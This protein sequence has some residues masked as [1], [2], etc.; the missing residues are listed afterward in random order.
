V[1][2]KRVVALKMILAGGHAGPQEVARF[3]VEAEAAARLQ[4]PHIVQIFETGQHAGLPYFSLEFCPGGSLHAKLAGTP[5]PPRAAARLVEQLAQG[6]AYAHQKGIVH[7]D[8][9]PGNVLLAEDGTPKI[10]DFGLAKHLQGEPGAA[11]GEPGALATG[12]LTASGAVMGTPSYMAPEQAGGKSGQVG[13]AADVYALGA[14]LYECLTGRPPFRAATLPETLLQ[15][16][17]EEPVAVRQLQPG[18]P[19]DLETI[20]HK[21]LQKEPGKRYAGAEELAEDLRRF[22][23]GEPI[24]AR[25][26]GPMERAWRWCRRNPLVAGLTAAVAAALLVGATV[27]TGFALAASAEARRARESERRA[28]DDRKQADLARRQAEKDKKRANAEARKAVQEKDE[29]DR[30]LTRADTLLYASQ[31]QRADE[32]WQEGKCF[33][34]R[35]LLNV[36]KRDYRRF[37][38]RY[39]HALF[40]GSHLSFRGHIEFVSSVAFSPDGKRLASGSSDKTVKVWNVQTGQDILTFKGHTSPVLS[41]AFSPNG[42]RLVSCSGD[43]RHSP[44]EVKVWDAQTGRELLDLKG[45]KDY[46]LSVA[47]SPDGKC[48]AS[49]SRDMTVKVWDAQ[50]GRQLLDLKGHTT[51]VDSVAFSP[52]GRRL[53]SG[54]GAF[55]KPGE[56]KIWDL[57]TGLEAIPLKGHADIVTSVVFSPD[58]KHLATAS[59]DRAV[60]VWDAQTGQEIL[61][62]KGH[63]DIVRSVAFSPDGQSLATASFDKTVKVWD[64]HAGQELFLLKGH[65][66]AV[67]SVAFSPDGQ[68]LASGSWDKIV[69]VWDARTGQQVLPIKEQTQ[70]GMRIAFSPDGQRLASGSGGTGSPIKVRICDV[71]TGQAIFASRRPLGMLVPSVAFSPDGQR[72]A[73]ACQDGTV[74][75]WNPQ[76]GQRVLTLRGHTRAVSSVAFSSDSKRLAS[77]SWD[78]TVKVWDALKGRQLLDLKG[79]NYVLSVAFSPD[80]RRLATA[81]LTTTGKP[82]DVKVWDARTG[83]ELLALKGQTDRVNSLAFSPDGRHLASAALDKTVKVWDARTGQETFTLKGHTDI[84]MCV[85]FSPDGKHLASASGDKTVKLWDARTGLEVLSLRGHT[86]T[87]VSV[88]FSPDGECLASA[89]GDQTVKVWDAPRREKF[90]ARLEDQV[91]THLWH[92]RMAQQ[93]RQAD[94]AF[95]L[96]FHLKP[97]LLT[98]FTRWQDRPHNFFPFWAWRPPVI[99]TLAPVSS[100]QAVTVTEAELRLLRAELDHLVQSK[101]K[102]WAA[103]A[104]RGWCC[105]LLGEADAALADLK[106]AAA[107]RPD[108]PGLWAL[109]GAIYLNR[110]RRDEAETIRQRLAR[111]PGV[112]VAIWHSLEAD[113][114]EA[115]G[116]LATAHWHLNHLVERQPT[117]PVALLLRRGRLCLARGKEKAAAADFARAVRCDAQDTDALVWHARTCLAIGD[118]EGYGWASTELL[119]YFQARDEFSRIGRR[120]VVTRALMLAPAPLLDLD[121]AQKLLPPWGQH[122]IYQTARGGLWLRAGKLV[123]AIAELRKAAAQRL[124]GEAPVAEL[125]LAVA[126]HQQGQRGDARQALERAR[127]ALEYEGLCQALTL[128]SGGAGG[129]VMATAAVAA[130]H[131]VGPPPWDWPTQL[132]IRLFRRE[133]EAVEKKFTQGLARLRAW[134]AGKVRIEQSA[135]LLGMARSAHHDYRCYVI[136][137]RLFTAY[138]KKVPVPRV[139]VGPSEAYH[140]ACSAARAGTGQGDARELPPSERDRYRRQALDWLRLELARYQQAFQHRPETTAPWL[141][142]FLRHW[143]RDD[144]LR[145]VRERSALAALPANER[146]AWASLWD[147]VAALV[148]RADDIPA[149]QWRV[150]GKELVQQQ[151]DPGFTALWLFGDPK[152]TDYDFEL[153][154]QP[155]RGAGEVDAVVRASGVDDFTIVILGGW[156]NGYH[157]IMPLAG[158]QFLTPVWADGQTVF[159]R[160]YRLKAEV[161]GK[162]CRLFLDG[163]LLTTHTELPSVSGQVGL[164][165]VGTAARFR[166]LKVTDPA[167]KVLFE[168]LPTLRKTPIR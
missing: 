6:M 60:K 9:K 142:D 89:S 31:I 66:K 42:R 69:K 62:I 83:R 91:R 156:H 98:A 4:H 38:Y 153:E 30:Q 44:G 134:E 132:E 141:R 10:T 63:T 41:V 105:H 79:H 1:A 5:Q 46:V 16:L 15:V 17:N 18:A 32:F 129:P 36:T 72:L 3:L 101:P 127:F 26:V 107:L 33:D 114:C 19:A 90:Q 76:T 56:V 68:R 148:R 117:V 124:A 168:G 118:L 128:F 163:K 164:R 53:A 8:L 48:L 92:L 59:F 85:A 99:R 119:R 137:T 24:R 71:Q 120:A 159:K 86:D 14:I 125:L 157:G 95:A 21:C 93:A 45:H 138:L 116:A 43:D 165:T 111:W 97:L 88:A 28:E 167:G 139:V 37:E 47:F 52:D 135:E 39:L 80:G 57:Q 27:A 161:R 102:S 70:K 25:P 106:H 67:V 126:L 96:A 64:A 162:S 145:A 74:R 109:Q 58:S 87:V 151:R 115:E 131:G 54:S 160:W 40:D 65:A 122:P 130:Y 108:Q 147:D 20:C 51:I 75:V 34:A 144:D 61:M 166:K 121:A 11:P 94:D 112:N 35:D 50:N 23:A 7:R 133:A 78:K 110:E 113:V 140:A 100:P 103:W 149:G 13:P 12:G 136:A 84:V 155:T 154:V 143:Q 152:W 150:Q 82:G 2:L 49:A 81:D 22:Q 158:G 77:A 55:G 29:K 104:A 146:P 73:G 123:E